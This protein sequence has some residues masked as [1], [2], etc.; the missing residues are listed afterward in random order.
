M[1]Y[2]W[3]EKRGQRTRE[4]RRKDGRRKRQLSEFPRPL[5]VCSEDSAILP[6]IS[7][8]FLRWCLVVSSAKQK[9][10]LTASSLK[11]GEDHQSTADTSWLLQTQMLPDTHSPGKSQ[12]LPFWA[13][14]IF[15]HCEFV[16]HFVPCCWVWN[17]T[18]PNVIRRHISWPQ[19]H[20]Y[21]AYTNTNTLHV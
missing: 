9:E 13:S 21:N 18:D 14:T 20:K 12:H 7:S 4:E 5:S 8:H 16:F 17:E 10:H 11:T 6:L 19:I 1:I 3:I 2:I 15:L